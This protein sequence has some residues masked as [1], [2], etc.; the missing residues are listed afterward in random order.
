MHLSEG[1]LTWPV[2]A[3]GAAFAV[4]GTGIGLKKLKTE[5]IPKTAILSAAF[6]VASLIHVPIGPSSAHLILNGIIGILLG[7]AAF[8]AIMVALSLQALFFQYGGITTL[9]VNTLLMAL[10]AVLCHLLFHPLIL[11]KNAFLSLAAG[12]SGGAF[13]VF[14]SG[15]FMAAFLV[16]AQRE[17]FEVSLL[18]IGVHIPVMI[19][20]GIITMF[21]IGFLKKVQPSLM[22]A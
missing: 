10:P 21:C 13:S 17:F 16:F 8:P 19:I 6:F 1:I 22:G 2:L 18:I 15:I 9:G 11:R 20:E 3:S 12:F 7:W 5:D 14:L 4:A